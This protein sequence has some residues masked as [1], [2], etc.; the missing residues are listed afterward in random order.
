MNENKLNNAAI[1][2]QESLKDNKWMICVGIG[3]ENNEASGKDIL[4][5][6]ATTKAAYEYIPKV[7]QGYPTRLTVTQRPK[8]I[9]D[10]VF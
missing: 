10:M 3:K 4:Y 5:V 8:P 7:W 6:Y 9:G 2:L 1:A